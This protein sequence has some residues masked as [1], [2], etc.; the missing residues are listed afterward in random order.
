MIVRDGGQLFASLLE[1]AAP[2]VD[3]IVVGDTGSCDDSREVARLA[4]AALWAVPWTDDFSAAR[5]AVLDRCSG[6]WILVLDADEQLAPGDWR[7]LRQWVVDREEGQEILAATLVIRDYLPGRHG[8]HDWQP[9]P[10]PDRHALP[11]GNPAPG[12]VPAVTVRLVPNRPEIR[13]AGHL[14]ETFDGSLRAACLPVEHL[15]VSVHHFGG[16]PGWQDPQQAQAKAHLF[17]KLARLKASANPHLPSAWAELAHCAAACGQRECALQAIDR[18][19]VLAPLNVEY[20]L[21]AGTLLM[22]LGRPAE[23]DR[24]LASVTGSG[25][26][27]DPLLAEVSHL[28]GQIALQNGRADDAGSLLGLAVRLAPGNAHYLNTLARWHA[29]ANRG[30]IEQVLAPC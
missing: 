17:L 18:A 6:R 8:R 15:P 24:R 9:N 27:A 7:H 14:K 28:R 2:H 4:G 11:G 25:P 3:E 26:V 20:Q 16:L 13:Y 1:A 29:Q 5:N 21:T 10:E 30:E 23:A 19:L 12:F 22:D